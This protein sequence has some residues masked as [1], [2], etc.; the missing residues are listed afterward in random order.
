MNKTIFLV[1]FLPFLFPDRATA[2]T[3]TISD[4]ET[5]APL[6]GVTLQQSADR[7]MLVTDNGGKVDGSALTPAD[8]LLIRMLGY[9]T[10]T[11]PYDQL[12]AAGFTWF[13]RP[14]VLPLGQVVVSASRWEQPAAEVPAAVTRIRS[15]DIRLQQPQTAADLL[16][17][18]GKVFIQKSQQGG[19]SPMVRGFSSNRL[20]YAVDGV[21][22][23]TAIFRS[24]NLQQ[25]IS[26]DPFSLERTE[27]LFGPG[28]VMYG[29]DAIGGVMRFETLTPAL[30]G[31]T[32]PVLVRGHAAWRTATAN[33]EQTAH[34]DVQAGWR[35]WALLTS[36]SAFDFDDLR[37]G[38]HGPDEYLRPFYVSRI[39]G[40][41]LTVANPDPLV[42][43]PSG[44]SQ[45]NIM[46]KLRYQPHPDWDVQLA[47]HHSE[48]SDYDRYDRH[49][50]YRNGQPRY[51]EWRYGPQSWGMTLL[52][53][54]HQ[55]PNA[56]YDEATVRLARQSFGES[57]I[58][59]NIG[60]AIREI[61]EEQ[62]LAWSANA[63][64]RKAW[65]GRH[66]LLYGLEAVL[67]RVVSTGTDEDIL[68][69]AS[70]PG[71]ARYPQ[72]DWASLGAYLSYHYAPAGP[73]HGQAGL[74]YS[75]NT[76]DARFDTRFYPFPFTSA[77]LDNGSLTGSTGLTFRPSDRWLF[78]GQVATAFRAPNVDDMGKVF[79]SEPGAVTVPNPSLQ[80]EYA[81]QAELGMAWRPAPPVQVDLA[82]Y[83]T[84]LRN[85][86]VRRN[87]S[88]DGR[89]SLL[90]D[91]VM[92][93]VQAVVN[94]AHAEVFGVQVGIT[95]AWDNGIS[96]SSDLNIQQGEEELDDGTRSPSRHAPP[97]FGTTRL[98]YSRGP[99]RFQ[100]YVA[101]SGAR[102]Y[103]QLAQEE[104]G[105]PE[106]YALDAEGRPW[107]PAWYTL[108][109][110]ASTRVAQDW[111]LTAGLENLTDRRYRTYSSGIAAAGRQLVMA[112]QCAFGATN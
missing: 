38:R 91:G 97:L 19:G 40:Q 111:T 77:S 86:M 101:Y 63:D 78:R 14:D 61:R 4:Q 39:D 46:Q 96:F 92:S 108:N 105:K 21:R 25:V 5:G 7:L 3:I 74:R 44:Y 90:Y 84:R 42:Q 37:M 9:R 76:L 17:I 98:G 73:W 52:S 8:T 106:I 103:A 110:K 75:H 89:D 33:R 72:A 81:W 95:A 102:R 28:S 48:T 68:S 45:L 60:A 11:V 80:A 47:L 16:G 67:D 104:R 69:G 10:D 107:S 93:R 59:R 99:L 41:D 53:V 79:D 54:R 31:P 82:G 55:A 35:K 57:R 100:W 26:L 65:H 36:V 1:L 20:L 29:S 109:F 112:L 23:N 6:P 43:R 88:L 34:F 83:Y 12:Q 66:Q 15:A 71:P 2:Q 27:V 30:A 87:F 58:S 24:G 18:S 56:W 94:A 85:A 22:M 32:K 64:F 13:L 49:I 51:G 70:Q 62:V 50:R